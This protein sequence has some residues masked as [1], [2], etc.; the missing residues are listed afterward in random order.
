MGDSF[1]IGKVNYEKNVPTIE[2]QEAGRPRL[3]QAHVDQGRPEGAEA[4]PGS[5]TQ[6]ADCLRGIEVSRLIAEDEQF[7]PSVP[8]PS[9]VTS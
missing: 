3:S 8:F 1:G 6:E 5:R 9:I 2:S 4:P 7:P